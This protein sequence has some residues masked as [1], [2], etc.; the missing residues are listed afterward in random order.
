[1]GNS[2]GI[3]QGRTDTAPTKEGLIQ[4]DLLSVRFRNIHLDAIYSSTLGRAMKTAEAIN[5]F[6][7]LDITGDEGLCEIY[8][9]KMD[10]RKWDDFP[11]YYPEE[12]E[13]WN[14]KPWK[15]TSDGGETMR[16]VYNRLSRTYEKIVRENI[17]KTIAIVSHGC[18]LR[19]LLCYCSGKPIE[20]LNDIDFGS[21]TA[22]TLIHNE[23]GKN[24]FEY[25][26]DVSHIPGAVPRKGTPMFRM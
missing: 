4:L 7:G 16:D 23:D 26:N 2:T 18:A 8:V 6:H 21:N 12:A 15:F 5:R 11:K 17:G 14:Y 24:N 13:N 9:G 1:M 22:V 20:E 19:N 3:F 10:G 25:I